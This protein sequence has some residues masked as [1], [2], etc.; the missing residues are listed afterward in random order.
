MRYLRFR[1]Q[2]YRTTKVILSVQSLEYR[3]TKM[4]GEFLILF[5]TVLGLEWWLILLVRE[6]G[7]T[8]QRRESGHEARR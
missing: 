5:A 8:G 1:E 7:K 2:E 4:I 3:D 6:V